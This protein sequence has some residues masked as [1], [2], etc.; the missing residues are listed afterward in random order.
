[1]HQVWHAFLRYDKDIN[2]DLYR[3]PMRRFLIGFGALT[4]IVF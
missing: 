1:M 2:D 4:N 3:L